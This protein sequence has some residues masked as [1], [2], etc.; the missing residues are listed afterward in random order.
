M[1]TVGINYI[2]GGLSEWY[3][4]SAI[5]WQLIG[6]AIVKIGQYM[7]RHRNG[8]PRGG[9]PFSW[10]FWAMDNVPLIALHL[11]IAIVLVRFSS[12]AV[13]VIGAKVLT[14]SDDPMWV[15]LIFGFL[16][17]SLLEVATSPR[18][19]INRATSY[20]AKRLTNGDA[21]S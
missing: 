13:H 12:Q 19:Y 16:G 10:E 2:T 5:V 11:L 3:I 18:K 1:D 9:E 4:V 20:L 7:R 17:Q 14:I 15:Y 21:G 6:L 8:P